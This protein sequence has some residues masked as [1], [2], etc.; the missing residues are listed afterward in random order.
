M[1]RKPYTIFYAEPSGCL[2]RAY[3]WFNSEREC[4]QAAR[5]QLNAGCI[6]FV[7]SGCISYYAMYKKYLNA[8]G[9]AE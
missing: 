9:Y 2:E 3:G 1:E 8:R 6:Y 7:E 5:E 4:I